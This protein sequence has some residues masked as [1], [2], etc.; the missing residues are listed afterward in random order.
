[1][2]H[3]MLENGRRTAVFLHDLLEQVQPT[4][5]MPGLDRVLLVSGPNRVALVLT[6]SSQVRGRKLILHLLDAF[7]GCG[8]KQVAD[9]GVVEHSIDKVIDEQ[10]QSKLSAQ[11]F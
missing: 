2:S 6:C 8:P 9:H 10:T 11:F 3:P 5:K 4:V 7:A 1:M